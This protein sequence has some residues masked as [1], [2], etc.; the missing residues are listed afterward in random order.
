MT[1]PTLFSAARAALALG[2]LTKGPVGVIIPVLVVVPVV[3]LERRTLN[4]RLS[5]IL[6]A[7]LVFAAIALAAA[8]SGSLESTKATSR[9][10]RSRSF[11]RMQTRAPSSS[12]LAQLAAR[13]AAG[14][15]TPFSLRRYA[16]RALWSE[17]VRCASASARYTRPAS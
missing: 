5:D 1:R 10:A 11:R 2:F 17:S 8:L 13:S 6:A 4:L 12:V 15:Y 9:A 3:L 16:S 7:S 14:S